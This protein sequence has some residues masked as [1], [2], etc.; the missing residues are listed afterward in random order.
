[1]ST[2][3]VPTAR[4]LVRTRRFRRMAR[5]GYTVNG[6]IHFIIGGFAIRLAFGDTSSQE[7]DPS[8][9]IARLASGPVGLIFVWAALGAL[10]SLGIWQ[11]TRGGLSDNPSRLKRWGRR[12]AESGKGLASLTLAGT[13]LIFALGGATSSSE[14][15]RDVNTALLTTSTGV[16]ILVG[17][18]LTVFGSGIGFIAI[19]IRRGFRKL[20]RIP[21]GR[22]G[23]IVLVLGASG[24]IAKGISLGIVGGTFV[25]AAVTGD[26]QQAS[27]LDGALR[28]LAVPPLGTI[29][30]VLV[31][32]GLI[33]Y[34]IFL[35]TRAKLARL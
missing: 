10:L 18:G 2:V 33:N 14:T 4:S 32:I 23:R 25:A 13:V 20:I 11:L 24:Y 9:A 3:S 5:T 35:V 30:L 8:G 34:G 6:L 26:A 29:A 15:T 31:G 21:T 19:G 22:R 7:A 27:G 12:I 28:L 1:M 17:V 16:L